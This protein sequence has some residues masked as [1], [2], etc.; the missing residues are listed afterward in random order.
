MI[1]IHLDMPGVFNMAG[2]MA[3][4]TMM[5][6]V[7]S[8]GQTPESVQTPAARFEQLDKTYTSN[9]RKYHAPIIQ[10]YLT[11]L[12]KLKQTMEQRDRN[13]SAASVQAEIDKVRRLAA[14]PG[15]LP[16]DVLKPAPAANEE[17]Q[18]ASKPA[19]KSTKKSGPA[20]AVILAA[21]A[22]KS[23]SIDSATFPDKPDGR[24]VA[25]GSAEWTIEKI[26]AG[27]YRVSILY[28]C[29]GKPGD[30]N[31]GVRLAQ[32]RLQH[33]LTGA[34]ATGGVNEFRIARL[35][36]IRVEKDLANEPLVLQNSDPTGKPI[37]VRQVII[38][39]S[40]EEDRK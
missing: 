3:V 11:A 29:A 22:A 13:E 2:F 9:L 30:A 34:N 1:R 19:E 33:P 5:A 18:P 4:G 38:S 10:E 14:G 16:Y 6:L 20:V 23:D 36:L 7:K 37:W 12:E 21:A 39:K 25:V 35:G 24:A 8:E 27:E 28:S 32:N 17:Q 26:S 15:L 31:M 40:T